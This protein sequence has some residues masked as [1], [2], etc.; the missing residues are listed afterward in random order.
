[1]ENYTEEEYNQMI[2]EILEKN[3]RLYNINIILYFYL[4]IEI[5]LFVFDYIGFVF[6]VYAPMI[7]A[8]LNILHNNQTTKA[9][10]VAIQYIKDMIDKENK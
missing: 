8:W 9:N 5:I 6:M 10:D 4:I 3:I 7:L 2:I 1:M